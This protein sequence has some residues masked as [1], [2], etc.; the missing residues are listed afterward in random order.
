MPE[1]KFRLPGSSYE[2]LAKIIKGYGHLV[3]PVTPQEVGSLVGMHHTIV[4]RSNAFL[5]AI[6]VLEG[7]KKKRITDQG[8]SLRI[9]L[10][11]EISEQISRSWREIVMANEF[12]QK[13]V[14]AVKVRKGME[15]STLKSHVAYSAG[16]S[17]TGLVMTG[18]GAII[19]ILKLAGVLL[20]EDGKLV[21]AVGEIP[22]PYEPSLPSTEFASRQ[23][24]LS[25][26][27][28]TGVLDMP[29]VVREGTAITIQIQI[30]CSANEV[31]SLAPKLR[32]LLKEI[33]RPD[34]P[35]GTEA[36]E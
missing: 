14:S 27:S 30:Q 20:E 17:K 31:E 8:K 33:S 23:E 15:D 29:P 10:E 19:E 28:P 4:S 12:L 32:A 26:K 9:A 3:S 21:T 18:A 35:G 22:T 25:R 11:H 6:G 1:E 7:G 2:E 34:S 13:I 5:V 36:D 24:A 16:Q